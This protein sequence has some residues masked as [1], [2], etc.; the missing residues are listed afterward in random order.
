MST[1]LAVDDSSTMRKCLE[2]TFAGS[3]LNLVS[4]DSAS[5]A[6]EKVK[7]LSPDLVIVD[8]SLPPGDG[9]DLCATLKLTAPSLLVLMLTS[10]H[11]PFDPGR[12]SQC[13]DHIDK[14]FDTQALYDKA[15]SM[16][17]SRPKVDT[18]VP[19][20]LGDR[21]AQVPSQPRPITAPTSG[22]H[23][24]KPPPRKH[25]T[26][27]MLAA[28]RE[29][30]SQ[31]RMPDMAR[32]T[33]PFAIP[34]M[35]KTSP[36]F[37]AEPP[38]EAQ[39]SAG[40]GFPQPPA[41]G[42]SATGPSLSGAPVQPGPTQPG[43]DSPMAKRPVDLGKTMTFGEDMVRPVGAPRQAVARPQ[44]TG[45]GI[46]PGV[47]GT[48]SFDDAPPPAAPPPAQPASAQPA[49][50]GEPSSALRG[51]FPGIQ[52]AQPQSDFPPPPP[53]SA[54]APPGPTMPE[55]S[56]G[57]ATRPRRTTASSWPAP[58]PDAGPLLGGNGSLVARLE[59]LGLTPAQVEGVLSLSREVVEQVVWEVVP[60]LA[61]TLIK[62]EI[63]RLT[64][65]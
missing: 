41:A 20:A 33:V 3:D 16:V 10:K 65:E 26:P 40:S 7:A 57:V 29:P 44:P 34:P 8:A 4:C 53:P 60:T 35:A 25:P 58:A 6:L 32:R 47:R 50:D 62:E 49:S 12:G 5:S 11:H 30:P 28:M 36:G 39:R 2:I 64:E 56:E 9:Y 15:K 54:G 52:P 22:K 48:H 45:A 27:S 63:R 38:F 59:G 18:D 37:A 43:A 55:P 23:P 24:S 51:T 61:E 13:D 19:R 14:P 21:P 46:A 1:I 17:G 31:R 42:S